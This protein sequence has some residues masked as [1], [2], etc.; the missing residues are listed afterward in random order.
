MLERESY[1]LL[2][3][4][5]VSKQYQDCHRL[6]AGWGREK[7]RGRVGACCLPVSPVSSSAWRPRWPSCCWTRPCVPCCRRPPKCLKGA[8]RWGQGVPQARFWPWLASDASGCCGQARRPHTGWHLDGALPAPLP[9]GVLPATVESSTACN[10]ARF[11]AACRRHE[12]CCSRPSPSQML[13][14]TSSVWWPAWLRVSA[15]LATVAGQQDTALHADGPAVC[16]AAFM[17][18]TCR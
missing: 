18:L 17:L 14:K 8:K 12:L 7:L 16:H 13:A 3:A 6:P 10:P 15:D 9:G 5:I 1:G 4:C 2:L 11:T